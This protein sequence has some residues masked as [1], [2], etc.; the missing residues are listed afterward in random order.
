[1]AADKIATSG[2]ST[3]AAPASISEKEKH[4]PGASWKANEEHV[5]PKNRM[6]IVFAGLM[7]CIFLAALDSTIVAT[8]LPTIVKDLGGGSEYSWVGTAY[9]LA[10]AAL[11]PLYGKLSDIVGRKPVLFTCIGIFLLGSALCGAAQNMTWLVICRAVQGIGG[12]GI[13]QIIQVTISDITTLQDR[14]RYAG[15]LG[16]AWGLASVIGP[17]LGGALTDHASW[18]WC[19]FINLPTGAVGGL[20]LFFFLNL[21]PHQGKSWRE[22]AAEFDFIG[23]LLL[24]SGVVLV[25]LGFSFSQTAWN[26]PETIACLVIGVVLLVLAGINETYTTR[27]PILPPRLFKTR[28]TA[29]LLITVFLHA[30]TFFVA[31]YY[32]PVYFQVMGSSATMAGVW[33]LPFSLAASF[34]SIITGQIISR[35]GYWVPIEWIS[36]AIATLGFGLMTMLDDNSN[37]YVHCCCILC[38]VFGIGGALQTPLIGLLAAMPIKDTATT[39]GSVILTRSLGGTV[40]TTIG[41]VIISSDF[42]RRV[43]EVPGLNI[44]TSASAITQLV[45]VIPKIQDAAQRTLLTHLYTESMA[46]IWIAAAPILGACTLMVLFLRNYSLQRKVIRAEDK[47]AEMEAEAA[48]K[49]AG[50]LSVGD[51]EAQ[52]QTLPTVSTSSDLDE[53]RTVHEIPATTVIVDAEKK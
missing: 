17:L 8:A 2:T 5:L 1:M 33:T 32:L 40:G 19:F 18:R 51:V 21:N 15:L 36:M 42:R 53:E 26:T 13:I 12:G 47:A 27:S 49:G 7:C 3:P 20:I 35:T 6:G 14:G 16:A 10:T 28:T 11:C 31:A 22:H 24:I 39:T 37:A 4:A 43:A 50:A 25:L 34:S 44:D 30:V 9:L 23:L 46:T 29:I 41:L 48:A 45:T 38:G 52:T